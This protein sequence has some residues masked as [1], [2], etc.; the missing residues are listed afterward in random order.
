MSRRDR[1]WTVVG[2]TA[3]LVVLVLCTVL[4]PMEALRVISQGVLVL[5]VLFA[6]IV[7][8]WAGPK[9]GGKP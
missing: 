3:G 6:A 8:I 2:T 9:S 4:M 7:F 5:S 1:A